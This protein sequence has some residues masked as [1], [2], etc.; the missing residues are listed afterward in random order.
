[1]A[2][3]G[4]VVTWQVLMLWLHARTQVEVSVIWFTP[5]TGHSSIPWVSF[6]GQAD[7]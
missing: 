6:W 3:C 5:D 2:G 4:P 7:E 1:M